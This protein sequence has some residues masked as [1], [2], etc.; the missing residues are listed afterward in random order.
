M[1]DNEEQ[2]QMAVAE[3]IMEEW[4][5]VLETLTEN[6]L[7]PEVIE[8]VRQQFLKEEESKENE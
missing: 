6:S 5:K 4:K 7:S 8:E 2:T 1:S 3:I